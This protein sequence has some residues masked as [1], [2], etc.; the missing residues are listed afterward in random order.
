MAGLVQEIKVEGVHE[1]HLDVAFA[2]PL[3]KH[4]PDVV[5]AKILLQGSCEELGTLY[6]Y[7]VLWETIRKHRTTSSDLA[8]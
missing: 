1:I 6:Q 5:R 2:F 3:N 4:P 8:V 7:C